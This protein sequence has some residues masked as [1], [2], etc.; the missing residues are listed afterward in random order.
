MERVI[1]SESLR[2]KLS[3]SRQLFQAGKPVSVAQNS[4]SPTPVRE[5]LY[6]ANTPIDLINSA[7]SLDGRLKT[8]SS[9]EQVQFNPYDLSV[10]ELFDFLNNRLEPFFDLIDY[11]LDQSTKHGFNRHGKEHVYAV[12]NLTAELLGKA[13]Y[14][15]QTIKRGLIAAM[16]HD[17]GNIISRENHEVL[18]ALIIA[19]IFPELT[20]D[21]DQ[22]DIVQDAVILHN[23]PALSPLLAINDVFLPDGSVD[24]RH[25]I[26]FLRTAISPEAKALLIADKVQVGRIRI[27]QKDI[28]HTAIS[29]DLH[30]L[31]NL[32]METTQVGLSSEKQT[33]NWSLNFTPGIAEDEQDMIRFAKSPSG[34]SRIFVPDHFHQLHRRFTVGDHQLPIDHSRSIS[35]AFLN[36]YFD[37]LTLTIQAI[38]ALY[39]TVDMVTI[40]IHDYAQGAIKSGG[41]I[42][43][44]VARDEINEA[45][46][47]WRIKYLPKSKRKNGFA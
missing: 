9:S 17:I 29:E 11:S 41:I 28:D 37:K 12:T 3:T 6:N 21:T 43:E 46:R 19:E 20:R 39:P 14:D 1:K 13:G 16:S 26:E 2:R 35:S 36:L 33:F 31:V 44:V 8:V 45:F 47:Q 42:S 24:S 4:D 5:F 15:E 38:F 34:Q 18:S 10:N 30:L 22:W 7:F 32:M 23:E 25:R 40:E 27:T